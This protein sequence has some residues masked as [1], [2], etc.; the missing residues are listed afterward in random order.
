[1]NEKKAAMIAQLAHDGQRYGNGEP[2]FT[3]H[4][5]KVFDRVRRIGGDEDE[6]IV[7][8]LHDVVEDTI[9]TLSDLAAWGASPIQISAI[10]AITREP[11]EPYLDFIKRVKGNQIAKIV[12][13]QDLT[14]NLSNDCPA[15]LAGRYEGALKVLLS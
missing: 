10:A 11:N 1:M 7:A 4:V 2:Y 15:D 14:E 13:L 6:R 12:K 9:V 8:L 3:G 5:L